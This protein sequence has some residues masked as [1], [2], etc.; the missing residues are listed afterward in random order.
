MGNTAFV[1]HVE[2][3][4]GANYR[5]THDADPVP[6]LPPSL[7]GYRHTSPE[8]WLV[9]DSTREEFGVRDVKICRGLLNFECNG[10]TTWSMIS[11]FAHSFYFQRLGGCGLLAFIAGNQT[12]SDAMSGL[13]VGAIADVVKAD[14]EQAAKDVEGW[15]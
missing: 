7:L 3:L 11:P 5:L 15:F 14:W 6:L 8:F 10:G 13:S 2:A 12:E 4:P 1:R 9:G